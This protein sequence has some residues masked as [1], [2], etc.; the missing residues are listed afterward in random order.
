ML[1]DVLYLPTDPPVARSVKLVPSPPSNQASQTT[2]IA[3]S[4][5]GG[6]DPDSPET[7]SAI[8]ERAT[9]PEAKSSV[10]TDYLRVSLESRSVE[11]ECQMIWIALYWYF[12]FTSNQQ[13]VVPK[14][15]PVP[16]RCVQLVLEH[17]DPAPGVEAVGRLERLGLVDLE[18]RED[19]TTAHIVFATSFWQASPESFI[20]RLNPHRYLPVKPLRY[21]LSNGTIRHAK[22]PRAPT[23]KEPFYT[24]PSTCQIWK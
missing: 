1:F 10:P 24:R 5:C 7:I 2:T 13:I 3:V 8:F 23:F 16:E 14:G 20:S 21:T 4:I 9:R 18:S 15:K 12:H 17:D 19:G 11:Q 22:R 6:P